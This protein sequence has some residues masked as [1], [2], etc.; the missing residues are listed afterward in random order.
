MIL[1]FNN[2]TVSVLRENHP[3]SETLTKDNIMAKE[4]YDSMTVEE[5]VELRELKE[6]EYT[7]TRTDMNN[8]AQIFKAQTHDNEV[9]IE[10]MRFNADRQNILQKIIKR[11]TSSIEKK[12]VFY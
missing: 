3:K 9:V 4:L 11:I 10:Q 2:L 8:L 6:N 1:N 7:S 5:L 12:Q